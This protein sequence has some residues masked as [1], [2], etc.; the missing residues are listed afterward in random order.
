MF[1][2]YRG[3]DHLQNP[4]ADSESAVIVS[5]FF[6][7][8]PILA[9]SECMQ[10]IG[11]ALSSAME[12]AGFLF[13]LRQNVSLRWDIMACKIL[14]KYFHYACFDEPDSTGE[15]W[16]FFIQSVQCGM[17]HQRSLCM[18]SVMEEKGNSWTFAFCPSVIWK[19]GCCVSGICLVSWLFSQGKQGWEG[20]MFHLAV[21]AYSQILS[22][23]K[24]D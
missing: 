1:G 10:L 17:T 18:Q 2:V 20:P 22:L 16:P 5:F 11:F 14:Q 3:K 6:G 24:T 13:S 12:A 8:S 21:L 7:A 19:E 23:I 15:V 9:C 4:A